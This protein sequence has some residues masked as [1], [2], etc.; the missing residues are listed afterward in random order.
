MKINNYISQAKL[1]RWINKNYKN[2]GEIYKPSI[3]QMNG[4]GMPNDIS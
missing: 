3:T 4:D 1:I 2:G